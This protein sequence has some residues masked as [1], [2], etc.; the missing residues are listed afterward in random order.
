MMMMMSTYMYKLGKISTMQWK[1]VA[2]SILLIHS[3]RYQL[4]DTVN[5]FCRCNCCS[6]PR[7]W[8]R[9]TSRFARRP[10]TCMFNARASCSPLPRSAPACCYGRSMTSPSLLWPIRPTTDTTTLCESCAR[11]TTLGV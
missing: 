3:G 7:R 4:V 6:K 5:L 2:V 8:N 1:H 10:P 11:L 9:H